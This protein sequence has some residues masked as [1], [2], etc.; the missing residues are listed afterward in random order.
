MGLRMRKA[1]YIR[2]PDARVYSARDL[3][4]VRLRLTLAR[5]FIV[6][7]CSFFNTTYYPFTP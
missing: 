2:I 3:A 1:A 6:A 5:D 7:V 4:N